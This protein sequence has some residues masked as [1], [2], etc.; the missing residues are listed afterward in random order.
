MARRSPIDNWPR[1]NAHAARQIGASSAAAFGPRLQHGPKTP[2]ASSGAAR[3]PP[4]QTAAQAAWRRI[5]S[6]R[7]G[8]N[9]QAAP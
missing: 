3:A 5:S 1:R 7:P 4:W 8:G 2:N 9:P 6:P